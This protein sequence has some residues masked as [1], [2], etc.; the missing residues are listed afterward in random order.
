MDTV[1]EVDDKAGIFAFF[2]DKLIDACG[3]ITCRRPSIGGEVFAYRNRRIAQLQ[4]R[5]LAFLVVGK[6]KATLVSRSKDN[7]PSGLG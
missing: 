3:A 7:F 6:A 5:R 1:L 4:V 2:F